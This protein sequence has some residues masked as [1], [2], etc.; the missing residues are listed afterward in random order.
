MIERAIGAGV[1]FVWVAVDSVYGVGEVEMTLR[2]AGKGY[3]L[4]VA[5]TTHNPEPG[6]RSQGF[7]TGVIWN[8]PTLMRKVSSGVAPL[9][10]SGHA[11]C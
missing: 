6:Q 11:A 5:S 3:V 10:R 9:K 1:P 4:G 2:R 8:W 7:T